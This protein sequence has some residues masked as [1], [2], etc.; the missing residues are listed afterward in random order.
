MARTWVLRSL[1][2]RPD[3]QGGAAEELDRRGLLRLGAGAVGLAAVSQVLPGGRVAGEQVV[4]LP[5]PGDSG[6]DH[7]VVV[8]MENR[9]FDHFL[10]WLP[11]ADGVRPD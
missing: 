9:S 11:R 8:T 1:G 6:I 7:V 4:A 5:A 3:T 10:G 2:I